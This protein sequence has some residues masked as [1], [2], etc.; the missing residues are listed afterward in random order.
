MLPV[1][2]LPTINT[3]STPA[4]ECLRLLADA[5]A[6]HLGSIGAFLEAGIDIWIASAVIGGEVLIAEP[7]IAGIMMWTDA[8]AMWVSMPM[9]RVSTGLTGHGS[10]LVVITAASS[11]SARCRTE[12]QNQTRGQMRV[13]MQMQWSSQPVPARQLLA[14]PEGYDIGHSTH[15]CEELSGVNCL[16]TSGPPVV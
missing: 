16:F 15:A 13:Q 4:D 6:V 5:A 12:T 8:M 10:T 3:V 1:V 7:T 2:P 9:L 14:V 11:C